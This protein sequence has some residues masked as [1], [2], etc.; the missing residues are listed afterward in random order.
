MFF[1]ALSYFIFFYCVTIN[2][3]LSTDIKNLIFF[4][5]LKLALNPAL[6]SYIS[7]IPAVRSIS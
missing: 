5:A 2:L 4:F 6:T 7:I 3:V 1:I